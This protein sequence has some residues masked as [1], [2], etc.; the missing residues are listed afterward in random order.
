MKKT[1]LLLVLV[2]F[3]TG[4]AFAQSSSAQSS[5]EQS[6][7]KNFISGEINILGG[8]LM[9]ERMLNQ[10]MSLG[11]NLYYST[12]IFVGDAALDIQFRFYPGIMNKTFYVGASLGPHYHMG[13]FKD[14]YDE[15][16]GYSGWFASSSDYGFD[17]GIIFGV[18]FTPEAGWKFNFGKTVG[19]FMQTGIRLPITFGWSG[20]VRRDEVS[21]WENNHVE[22][23]K[24]YAGFGFVAYFGAGISF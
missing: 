21:Y 12:L 19:F 9:Y 20:W 15:F 24:V 7:A 11:V 5:S 4:G 14:E 3:V 6:F 18:A 8:G 23:D 2:V 22:D 17:K 10:K 16:M 1:V 13:N